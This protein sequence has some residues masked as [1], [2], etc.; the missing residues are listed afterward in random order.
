MNAFG[1]DL[2]RSLLSQLPLEES[3][4]QLLQL[5]ADTAKTLQMETYVVG[6]YVRDLILHRYVKDLDFVCVGDG[7][8]LA[9]AVAKALP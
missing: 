4:L 7:V 2:N 8:A 6:G 5:V 9:E 1:L 3:D